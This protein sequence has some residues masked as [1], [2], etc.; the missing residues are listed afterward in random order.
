MKIRIV[1]ALLCFNSLIVEGKAYNSSD[2]LRIDGYFLRVLE[3]LKAPKTELRNGDPELVLT[4]YICDDT[5]QIIELID[6]ILKDRRDKETGLRLSIPYYKYTGVY[7]LPRHGWVSSLSCRYD[8]KVSGIDRSSHI[9]PHYIWQIDSNSKFS[10]YIT[11]FS[12]KIRRFE[13]DSAELMRWVDSQETN[14]IWRLDSVFNI[15]YKS[16]IFMELLLGKLGKPK[17][18]NT[19]KA[20]EFWQPGVN[21]QILIYP[22][23][24][25]K[26]ITE[27]KIERGIRRGRIKVIIEYWF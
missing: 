22:R 10:F 26:T 8:G 2:T 1:L 3:R 18:V 7:Y 13:C 12:G 21:Q 20:V 19:K 24:I 5:N 16:P 11:T 9:S 23:K 14:S 25:P 4:D 15:D 27:R 17:R 6:L